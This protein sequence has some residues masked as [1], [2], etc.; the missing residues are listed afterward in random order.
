MLKYM[1]SRRGD[2]RGGGVCYLGFLSVGPRYSVD[3]SALDFLSPIEKAS[4]RQSGE[5][6]F[7][8]ET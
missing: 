1:P 6:R 5:I 7:Y 8:M 2:L 4:K 3:T